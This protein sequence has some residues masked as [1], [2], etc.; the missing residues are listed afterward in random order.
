M[1]PSHLAVYDY[2]TGG[3]WA[4]IVA[5]S[6]EAIVLRYPVL[7]VV[8]QRPEWMGDA[9]FDQLRQYDLDG[10]ADEFLRTP[11]AERTDS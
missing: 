2:G 7:K 1:K 11:V 10:D 9:E 8:E 3:V 6:T 4:V 5:E